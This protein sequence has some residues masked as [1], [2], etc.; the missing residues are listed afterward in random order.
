[1]GKNVSI[2]CTIY[3]FLSLDQPTNSLESCSCVANSSNMISVLSFIQSQ[4]LLKD[5][6]LNVP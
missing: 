6:V 1:M 3:C 2:A 4:H 5:M